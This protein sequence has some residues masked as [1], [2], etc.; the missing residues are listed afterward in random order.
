MI[1]LTCSFIY[2][3]IKELEETKKLGQA[4]FTVLLLSMDF[5]PGDQYEIK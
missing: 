2:Y 1:S 3:M 5:E 4:F